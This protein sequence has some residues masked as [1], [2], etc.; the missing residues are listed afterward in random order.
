M[1]L[2]AKVNLFQRFL[3]LVANKTIDFVQPHSGMVKIPF[4]ILLTNQKWNFYINYQHHSV[5]IDGSRR[6]YHCAIRFS[7]LPKMENYLSYKHFDRFK[8]KRKL[9]MTFT[10]YYPLDQFISDFWITKDMNFTL[11]KYRSLA[12]INEYNCGHNFEKNK[13]IFKQFVL[14]CTYFY[15]DYEKQIEKWIIT[16]I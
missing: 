15:P 11:E 3:R 8:I 9:K 12:Y 6:L 4:D 16:N 7:N 5:D 2:Q 10:Y 14:D 13:Y 1:N